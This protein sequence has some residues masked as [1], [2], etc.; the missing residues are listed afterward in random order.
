[1]GTVEKEKTTFLTIV[2][3]ILYCFGNLVA[4]SANITALGFAA[5]AEVKAIQAAE[6]A[7]DCGDIYSQL[8]PC[9]IV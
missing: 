8:F 2:T 1:M 6:V 7:N 9:R 4:T 5:N 3:V